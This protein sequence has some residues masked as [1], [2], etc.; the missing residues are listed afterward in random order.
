MDFIVMTLN[1]EKDEWE[2]CDKCRT[3]KRA[4]E[5]ISFYQESDAQEHEQHEYAIMISDDKNE[6]YFM[7]YEWEN[8]W[9]II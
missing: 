5:L 4:S 3:F 8:L 6:D 2:E 9:D 1:K 7:I